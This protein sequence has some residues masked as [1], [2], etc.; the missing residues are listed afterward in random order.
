M[1]YIQITAVQTVSYP[2]PE[3]QRHGRPVARL[4]CAW[5]RS[6]EPTTKGG[7]ERSNTARSC[8]RSGGNSH[9]P[10]FCAIPQ[11]FALT[12]LKERL[13]A[14][15]QRRP[16][17]NGL[18]K[19]SGLS[20]LAVFRAAE[21]RRSSEIETATQ[22]PG[23]HTSSRASPN[24]Q[25]TPSSVRH[26]KIQRLCI[27]RRVTA[28]AA[29]CVRSDGSPNFASIPA[30]KP[31]L[32]PSRHPRLAQHSPAC[33]VL[34]F[35][36]FFPILF[37]FFTSLYPLHPPTTPAPDWKLRQRYATTTRNGDGR[38][39]LAYTADTHTFSFCHHPACLLAFDRIDG[40]GV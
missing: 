8:A 25:R 35:S 39:T 29:S 17:D 13:G 28:D 34:F 38:T 9:W 26:Q 23:F 21:P 27:P 20:T 6:R 31:I 4:A 18:T 3:P 33:S 24:S 14:D 12:S 19:Q 11:P 36:G 22:K 5:R 7:G 10:F 37:F 15:K 30:V 1:S 16:A 32:R 40:C 2:C